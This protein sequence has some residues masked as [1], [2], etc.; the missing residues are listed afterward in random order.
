MKKKI[1][2]VG[3]G[4]VG[5]K[6]CEKLISKDV[7]KSFDLVVFGEE[8]RPAY[9]RVHLSE[10]FAGKTA[11]DLTMAPSSWYTEN[12]ITLYLSDPVVDIDKDEQ[13]VRSHHGIVVNY[14]Y[15]VLATGS[16]AFVPPIP[17]VEKDGV[18][19][20][21][22]I[23]D[24]DLMQAHAKTA[25]KGAVIG[26]GLL[27]LE[28][29]KA[30]LDLGLE[31][32][33]VIEFAP[34]LMPR[35]IDEAGS[36]TLQTKLEAL[37][38]QIH[39]NKNTQE[40]VGNGIIE[41]MAFADGS[42]L[43]VDMLVISAGIKPRDEVAKIAGLEVGSR[44]GIIVNDK[45]QTSDPNIFAIGECALAHHMIYGLVAPGYEMAEVV[46]TSIIGGEKEF[47]PFD[48]ST[49]LKLIGIDVASFGDAFIQEPNAQT[50]VF[51]NTAKGVYKRI[52]I[53][54]DGKYL[55]GGILVGDAE[56]YNMLLQNTKNKV[57]LP[58]DPEDLM[59]GSRG[60]AE[61]ASSGV[62]ALPDEALICSCEA[63]TKG[64]ICH[65]IIENKVTTLDG[66]KKCTKA[67]TGCGGCVPMVKD[68]IN[69]TMKSQ[70]VFVRNILCEHFDYTRQ[71]LFDLV[72]IKG[73]KTYND[74]LDHLGRG[75]GCEVCKPAVASII[76]SLW[77]EMILERGNATVQDSND[78]YLANIQ[79]NGTYSVVPRIPGGEI[80]PEKL[81]VIGQVAQKYNLYTKITGGQRIDLFGAHVSDLPDIWEELVNAGFESGH[82]YGKSL[83]TVKSCVGSTWCRF[84]VQDAVSFSI[85][86]EERYRGL[87]SPHKLKSAVS[88]CTRECA[89]A[90]SKDF[91]I[92]ATE[93]GWNLYV[94]GNGGVKPRHAEL[95]ATDIDS[96]TCL[97]YIDRFLMFYIKTAEPLTRTAPWLDKMEGG[98][99]Y[100]KSVVID[101]ALGMNS[102]FEQEMQFLVDAY[103]CE[104]KEVVNSPELRKRFTHFVNAPKMKDPYARF[105]P[106][107]EQIKAAEWK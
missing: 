23:E 95:L 84:G 86:V 8:S 85:E 104:W 105:E 2:V 12:G 59:L 74:V 22:T 34:R 103:K 50:I 62:M 55:L 46:A 17:G 11:D 14:D 106:M 45:L 36:K 18:F 61:S 37:G 90:Q 15:L 33:H 93:K 39:L 19:V 82:A 81:I 63:V 94:C 44:G 79:K 30:L 101:D 1:V 42:K 83:R 68:L 76:A 10:Y 69:E 71:E 40:I 97:K 26:G 35:Q 96:E 38:L 53:S 72:K 31:E 49:K 52:N 9:D 107:R 25:K 6:F 5:Y 4:M 77:N 21:R 70:G 3:N 92:I 7:S 98:I 100:L 27:G 57:L 29:A 47:K 99:N 58:A 102:Q 43:E 48:M 78:R 64:N 75:D 67:G 66:I 60:G 88:G 41:G 80:T 91:G 54:N 73:Y 32:T 28:A 89:E 24:L 13:T 65:E 87:R 16:A 20:Y 56:Q 51:E